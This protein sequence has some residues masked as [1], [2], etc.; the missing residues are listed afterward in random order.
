MKREF[1]FI[2][3]TQYTKKQKKQIQID[4]VIQKTNQSLLDQN[5]GIRRNIIYA[6]PPWE[7]TIKHHDKGTTMTGLANQHY[8]T[9]TLNEL[10]QLKVKEIAAPDCIL[11]LWTTGPQLNNATELMKS[12]GFKYKTM[13]MTW[14]KTTNG[15]VKPNRLGFYTRQSCE[16]VLMG[17]RGSTLQ[18]KDPAFKSAIC[19]TFQADSKEHSRKPL[20][21]RELIDQMFL[22]VPKIELFAREQSNP[23][24]WDYWGNEVNLFDVKLKEINDAKPQQRIETGKQQVELYQQLLCQQKRDMNNNSGAIDNEEIDIVDDEPNSLVISN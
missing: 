18:L 2:D 20:Y 8:P 3:E 22:N 21:V 16:C 19:N 13:F 10:K 9:M 4:A 1:E 7:Y 6:D 11:F 15:Q 14:V 24:D 23:V 5:G 17:C 12:W